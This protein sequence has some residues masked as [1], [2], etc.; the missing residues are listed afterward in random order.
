MSTTL[1]QGRNMIG[2]LAGA[3]GKGTSRRACEGLLIGDMR[4]IVVFKVH[5][6]IGKTATS[7]AA[8]DRAR[9]AG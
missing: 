7:S 6:D 9:T 8:D 4:V 5:P 3:S 1:P 2:I